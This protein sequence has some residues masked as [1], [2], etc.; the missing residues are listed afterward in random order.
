MERQNIDP[1]AFYEAIDELNYGGISK[2]DV[3]PTKRLVK[4]HNHTVEQKKK[5]RSEHQAPTQK[6]NQYSV[7]SKSYIVEPADGKGLNYKLIDK[8]PLK[9]YDQVLNQDVIKKKVYKDRE[10]AF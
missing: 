8:K 7:Y 3:S 5:F 4:H 6:G 10:Q 9:F 1:E 2:F